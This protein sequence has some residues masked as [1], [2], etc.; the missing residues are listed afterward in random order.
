MCRSTVREEAAST[1]HILKRE[2]SMGLAPLWLD[3]RI[4]CL[5]LGPF[6]P[7]LLCLYLLSFFT[8]TSYFVFN[9]TFFSTSAL[10]H[11]ICSVQTIVNTVHLSSPLHASQIPPYPIRDSLLT[12]SPPILTAS[13]GQQIHHKRIFVK[14]ER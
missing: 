10:A 7:L 8:F 3:D 5:S 14:K 13:R 4:H 9:I 12:R 1:S 2:S 11:H 6:N